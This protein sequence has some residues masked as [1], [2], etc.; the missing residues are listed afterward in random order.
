MINSKPIGDIQKL[1]GYLY[2]LKEYMDETNVKVDI[3]QLCD[4]I[5][6]CGERYKEVVD[7][8]SKFFGKYVNI[9][10]YYNTNYSLTRDTNPEWACD[11]EVNV[12]LYR[13]NPSNHFLFGIFNRLGN[14]YSGGVSDEGINLFE[15][16]TNHA[17]EIN[18][19]TKEEFIEKA[20]ESVLN[21]LT[22]RV[23]LIE[24]D[25]Y[26]LTKNGYMHVTDLYEDIFNK[27]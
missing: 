4:K 18:E 17:I 19:I 25:N 27:Y 13:Y 7:Y 23:D 26:E 15:K 3:N 22:K 20:N 21:C 14:D 9:K 24:S 11:E 5:N 6:E 12:F 16:M 10:F 2:T 1:N 8:I